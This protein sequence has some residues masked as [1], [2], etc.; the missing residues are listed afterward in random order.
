MDPL[1]ISGS[2][3]G[4]VAI[5]GAAFARVATYIK[6][7]KDA[8]KEAERLL[9]EMKQFSVLLHHLSLVAREL[10]ITLKAGEEAVQDSPNLQLHH[11]HSCQTILNRIEIGLQR[12]RDDLKSSSTLTKLRSRLK[13]PFSLDHTNGMVQT[14]QH[15]KQTINVALSASSYSRLAMCLSRQEVADKLQEETKKYLISVENTV[16]EILEINTKVFLDERRREVLSYFTKFVNPSHDFEMVQGLRHPSTGLWFTELD[17]FKA[18][19]V[20][21]SS[22]LWVTGIPGAGK[23]VLA[24]L[25]L[26][27]CLKLSSAD[28]RKATIYFFC[29]YSDKSTHSARNLISSLAAQLACQNEEAFQILE[30]YQKE[31][32]SQKPLT[33]EPSV[34][35]LLTIFEYMCGMFD[36]IFVVVDGLDEC[37]GDEVIL[38]L[39]QLSSKMNS[40]SITTLLL[41]R[42]VV[43]IRDRLESR[44]VHIEI[45]AHTEDLQ[46][47]VSAELE[48]R[49]ELKQFRIR[50]LK[51]KAD[52][53][54]KLVHDAKGMF[55]WA[56][57]QL[58]YLGELPTDR[59]KRDALSKLP[60][61]LPATYERILLKVEQSGPEVRRLVHK[62][63]LLIRASFTNV[64]ILIEAVSI[65]E[66]SNV[67]TKEDMVDE[68][69]I[70]LRCGSLI[71]KSANG[72]HLEFSHFTVL[73]FLES[74]D[75]AHPILGFYRVSMST[76]Y[77]LLAQ[78]C[79]R[80]LMLEEFNRK[81]RGE[82]GY[83]HHILQRRQT[84]P[85][86]GHCAN[87]WFRLMYQLED[88][89]CSKADATTTGL[90]QALF[91]SPKTS[92]FCQWVVQFVYSWTSAN[93]RLEA[94]RFR[95]LD[96]DKSFHTHEMKTGPADI[97]TFIKLV[98][99][100]TRPDFT[101]LHMASLLGLPSLCGHL[102]RHGARVNLSSRF[103]TPLHCALGGIVVFL[104]DKRLVNHRIMTNFVPYNKSPLAQGQTVR[105]LLAAGASATPHLSTPFQQRTLMGTMHLSPNHSKTFALFPDLIR[106]GLVVNEE[107]WDDMETV[108]MEYEYLNHSHDGY[109]TLV[110]LLRDL[111]F[112]NDNTSDISKRLYST[113]YR[114]L[115]GNTRYWDLDELLS[116]DRK[117]RN[118][119]Q[120]IVAS[121]DVFSLEKLL[122]DNQHEVIKNTRFKVGDQQLTA[123]H[124]ACLLSSLDVLGLL[125]KIGVDPEVATNQGI[126]P[127]NIING[128][129]N[130]SRDILKILL[131]HHV[132]TAAVCSS[133]PDTIWHQAVKDEDIQALELLISLAPDKNEA[134]QV[135]SDYSGKTAMCIALEKR[136]EKVLTLLLEHCPTASFWKSDEPLY[137]QAARLGSLEVMN[138]LLD[139]G[140][141]LDEFDDELGSPLHYISPMASVP[142]VELLVATFPHCYRPR[143]D[144]L[145]PFSSFIAIFSQQFVKEDIEIQPQILHA[146]L[147]TSE[148]WQYEAAVYA[149]AH[150]WPHFSGLIGV[151][152]NQE[153]AKFRWANQVLT[154]FF[155]TGLLNSLDVLHHSVCDGCD[156]DIREVRHKCINC[157]DWDYCS[158]CVKHANFNHPNH[159][160]VAIY[161]PLTN[162]TFLTSLPATYRGFSCDGS[163]CKSREGECHC[164]RAATQP[165]NIPASLKDKIT[166]APVPV[167]QSTDQKEDKISALVLFVTAL[168]ESA[169]AWPSRSA[170]RQDR[171][172]TLN[173]GKW[174]PLK[175]W[176][177]LSSM[178][179]KITSQ[180]E[181]GDNAAKSDSITWL[182]SEAIL[183]DDRDL[184]KRLLENGADVHRPVDSMSALEIAC[185]PKVAISDDTL[186]CLLSYV[187]ANRL[188][189]RCDGLRGMPIIYF[190]GWRDY[191]RKKR[192]AQKLRLILEAG[193]DAGVAP[194]FGSALA[195]HLAGGFFTTAKV[196]L[197]FGVDPWVTNERG[198]NA[199][200]FAVSRNKLEFLK[201]IAKH[202]T[203][204]Q[205]A[206]KWNQTWRSPR[207][208]PSRTFPGRPSI[209]GA[210]VFHLAADLGHV[211]CM[212]LFLH[213]K[214]FEDLESVDKNLQTPMHYAAQRGQLLV[215]R[216][217]YQHG[218][219]IDRTTRDG[220][221][222]LHLAVEGQHTD[223]VEELLNLGAKMKT[224]VHGLSP[225]VYA[226]KTG[227]NQLIR[228]F[229]DLNN[230]NESMI[231]QLDEKDSAHM[232]E[233]FYMALSQ[234]DL[235]ACERLLTRGWPIDSEICKPQ[236]VTALMLAISKKMSSRA[237]EWLLEKGAKVSIVF[238]GPNMPE[239]ATALEAA[240]ADDDYNPILFTLI[241][242]YLNEGGNFNSQKQTPLHVAVKRENL[243]GLEILSRF[244]HKLPNVLEIINQRSSLWKGMT[245]LH[246]SAHLDS[247]DA[248]TLLIENGANIELT[249]LEGR[250]PL[251]YAAESGSINVLKLLIKY[252]ACIEPLALRELRTPLMLACAKGHVQTAKHLLRFQQNITGDSL[253]RNLV[254]I[255]VGEGAGETSQVQLCSFLFRRAFDVHHLDKSGECALL[256]IMKSSTHRILR[257]ILTEYPLSLRIQDLHWPS[258]W[259]RGILSFD[260][261]SL[262]HVAKAYR[263]IH[264]YLGRGGLIKVS[265][266]VAMGEYSLLY[267]ALSTGHVAAVDDL[268]SIG[269]DIDAE[270]CDEGTVLTVASVHGQLDAVKYLVR[271]G[272]RPFYQHRGSQVSRFASTATRGKEEVLEWL[273][274]NRY[275]EQAKITNTN[276]SLDG[277]DKQVKEW[278]GLTQIKLPL[279][280]EW[281]RRRA[282]TMLE[283]ANRFQK[284][285][286]SLHGEIM[287]ITSED[288]S[289]TENGESADDDGSSDE[290][291]L[292]DGDE[293]SVEDESSDESESSDSD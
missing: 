214:W 138:K 25:I 29:T 100:V 290:G 266:S 217:L 228:I 135:V 175:H 112:A 34:Q 141:E 49:I 205:L 32:V 219:D 172:H 39:L 232:T 84:R 280:W 229:R 87:R 259:V 274:V 198:F 45:A 102:L 56:A 208:H 96:G 240:I 142:C 43:G 88:G 257:H 265:D 158:D 130:R 57:C 14:I 83:L 150:I 18:W 261:D 113:I 234:G 69:E 191:Y 90:I 167:A 287:N 36:Q 24:G 115:K 197:E 162:Q 178:L 23:S 31:L 129:R 273:L 154:F 190:L 78:V 163:L 85:F 121:N 119:L 92:Q 267:L 101:P 256:N 47:Y 171:L 4:L 213:E 30:E 6:D 120:S 269:I 108:L 40:A 247:L 151:Y 140:I 139:M 26:Y 182:L 170:M 231:Y 33:L 125:L 289:Q 283:Y 160:F 253:G 94:G 227:N 202:S 239:Y 270:F 52:I 37:E 35:K 235:N 122:E 281:K 291:G 21:P 62:T 73:E 293:S 74:I 91:Q 245:A 223:V 211:D 260:R 271:R 126:K 7:V 118:D 131:L 216:F 250:T 93:I 173:R 134:L 165:R 185:I 132:S 252:R 285:L 194:F 71:R 272:A 48:K 188:N 286:K 20:T 128:S 246:M 264:R 243:G 241:E 184:M 3:A 95:V 50:N 192:S 53:I 146:L 66:D 13:W 159:Q 145:T 75:P 124:L 12:A 207:R 161:E 103:G 99:A 44:F 236:P 225:L 180:T 230:E 255:T 86:Y 263:L 279:K 157:L 251:H 123:V 156:K 292:S 187:N 89:D 127:I 41:S 209:S 203:S 189:E 28:D 183:H 148:P 176:N 104:H 111:K 174:R 193:A 76:A 5:A 222:P 22:K 58:D 248:A 282:E 164:S 155:D 1:S 210:N 42:D 237:V 60:P 152:V 61:T 27:E 143:K 10:E 81:P 238:E 136:N 186:R 268:L 68:Y 137:R 72:A 233:A 224:D 16:Q 153:S 218:C 38:S 254:A 82:K 166:T 110:Q 258:H 284:I 63:L 9:E 288:I 55:R 275:T 147:P 168:Y 51:L 59:E 144:R 17:E 206:A 106:A 77:N 204:H 133:H 226:Y 278:R 277:E 97:D 181:F 249:A 242:H 114:K 201:L 195:F 262:S 15:H 215:I 109:D 8:P 221:S 19:R 179:L 196:L 212:K 107:D 169:S 46:L 65:R 64:N 276:F 200:L 70:M 67:L 11:L 177:F 149:M 117:I 80:Y 98:D 116:D 199:A 54:D 2:V 220:K 244:L 105:L 79:L